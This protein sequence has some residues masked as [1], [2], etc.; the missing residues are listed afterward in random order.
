MK[1]KRR[2]GSAMKKEERKKGSGESS[3]MKN[4]EERVGVRNSERGGRERV[5]AGYSEE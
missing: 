1:R 2:D 5:R 4:L 3:E